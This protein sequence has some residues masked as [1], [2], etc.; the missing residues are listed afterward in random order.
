MPRT[1][2]E[3]RPSTQL[4]SAKLSAISTYGVGRSATKRAMIL[5][6]VI[7]RIAH[8]DPAG[9]R[10]RSG[11]IGLERLCHCSVDNLVVHARL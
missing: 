3:F 2:N 11:Y 10:A 1:G 9:Y 6:R 8:D 7:R 5:S 4:G